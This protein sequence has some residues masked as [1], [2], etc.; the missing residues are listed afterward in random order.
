MK[1]RRWTDEAITAYLDGRMAAEERA[2]FEAAL[3]ADGALRER[4]AA[5]QQVKRLL[6]AMPM[7]EPPR[8]YRL[9][10]AMV[11]ERRASSRRPASL[12]LYRLASA[13]AMV[14]LVAVG[15]L[16]MLHPPLSQRAAPPPPQVQTLGEEPALEAAPS[17]NEEAPMAA[18]SFEETETASSESGKM[19][20]M[21]DGRAPAPSPLGT[22]P[23]PTPTFGPTPA[24]TALPSPAPASD[25]RSWPIGGAG[26]LLLLLGGAVF[27][28]RHRRG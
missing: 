28:R 6:A 13:M 16:W 26:L 24:P 27:L 1:R 5:M 8:S 25:G 19:A 18:D 11:D 14:L 15:L 21:E 9:T 17:V 12:P 10:P 2:A 22:S 20:G 7:R 3:A 4:V 23:P